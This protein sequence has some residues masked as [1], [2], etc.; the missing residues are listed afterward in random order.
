MADKPEPPTPPP[1]PEP[2]VD[3]HLVTGVPLTVV[4]EDQDE[5]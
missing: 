1:A 3:R 4:S 2:K 5:R